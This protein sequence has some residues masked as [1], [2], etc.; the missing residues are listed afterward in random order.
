MMESP[1]LHVRSDPVL[2]GVLIVLCLC[3]LVLF[4]LRAFRTHIAEQQK[5]KKALLEPGPWSLV[6]MVLHFGFGLYVTEGYSR[7]CSSPGSRNTGVFEIFPSYWVYRLSTSANFYFMWQLRA[8]LTEYQEF[9]GRGYKIVMAVY[10]IVC[11]LHFVTNM[12]IACI[13]WTTESSFSETCDGEFVYIPLGSDSAYNQTCTEDQCESQF[14]QK[15]TELLSGLILLLELIATFS[16][17]FLFWA[18][19]RTARSQD[20]LYRNNENGASSSSDT[21]LKNGSTDLKEDIIYAQREVQKFTEEWQARAAGAQM[22]AQAQVAGAHVD[23]EAQQQTLTVL[24]WNLVAACM[25]QLFDTCVAGW[26]IYRA[27]N[28]QMIGHRP[29]QIGHFFNVVFYTMYYCLVFRDHRWAIDT[30]QRSCAGRKVR[31]VVPGN[32]TADE[33][34]Q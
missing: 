12:A 28:Y 34:K 17:I 16:T 9:Q 10:C 32:N 19:L 29:L 5:S 22:V 25:A 11:C 27:V 7:L 18:P 26:S 4:A 15:L 30:F 21:T 13:S 20:Y 24:Y 2:L 33:N 8:K 1:M 3:W 23:I 14:V 6:C 31:R